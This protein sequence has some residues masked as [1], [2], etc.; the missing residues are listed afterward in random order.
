M[1][2][3]QNQD[4]DQRRAEI[5]RLTGRLAVYGFRDEIGHLLINCA[6]Y[7]ELV[8]LAATGMVKHSPIIDK[9]EAST[10]HAFFRASELAQVLS[11]TRQAVHKRAIAGKWKYALES[12]RGGP[13]KLFAFDG[14][15]EDIQLAILNRL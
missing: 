1:I 8:R 12:G 13:R 5:E 3:L 2:L 6:D 4:E 14:L 15:P 7:I 9:N 10:G 11:V